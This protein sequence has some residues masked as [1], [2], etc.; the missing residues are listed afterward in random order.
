MLG[1]Q[2]EYEYLCKMSKNL[3]ISMSEWDYEQE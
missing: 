1:W 2:Y 3:S